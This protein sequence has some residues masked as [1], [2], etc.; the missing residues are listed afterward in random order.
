MGAMALFGEKY[1]DVVRVVQIG[2]FSIELCG[3]CHVYNT[4]EIGLFKIASE[5][6][7]GAG[8]RRIEAVTSKYAYNLMNDHIA[9]L[10][11]SAKLLKANMEQVPNRI[12]GLLEDIKSL[13]KTNESLMAKL[14]NAE[15]SS[16]TDKAEVVE[17]IKVLAEQVNATNMN[18]LR[19]MVDDL[20]QSVKSGVVLLAA[21]NDQKVMLSAGVTK[22]LLDKGLHAGKLIKKAAEICG[23][24]GGGRPDMA[25]AGGKQPE[26]IDKALESSKEYV[27]NELKR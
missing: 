21:E 6:G 19:S 8:T 23:G 20:K 15:A 2:N 22:D 12:E 1:G 7:I 10:N 9:L 25:Q 11:K 13:N 27:R 5:S 3:G 26:N 17:G 4:Q 14:S 24:G 18:Q 16:L